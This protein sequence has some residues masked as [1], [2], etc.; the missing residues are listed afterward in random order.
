MMLQ[1]GM[2][3]VN[4]EEMNMCV[5]EC[6]HEHI[7]HLEDNHKMA[8]KIFLATATQGA[9]SCAIATGVSHHPCPFHTSGHAYMLSVVNMTAL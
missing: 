8:R 3:Y 6:G 9:Y 4:F 5:V 1:R 7:H 2:N